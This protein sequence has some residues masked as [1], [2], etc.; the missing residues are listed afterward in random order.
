MKDIHDF[1]LEKFK[2][3]ADMVQ[4]YYNGRK[5]VFWGTSPLLQ[6]LL[7]RDYG[8]EVHCIVTGDKKLANDKLLFLDDF[9]DK[10]NEYYIVAPH[11]KDNQKTFKDHLKSLG[12][13]EFVDFFFRLHEKIELKPGSE[14]YHDSYGNHI[15]CKKASVVLPEWIYNATILV[16]DTVKFGKNSRI[17]MMACNSE[18]RIAKDCTFGTNALIDIYTS[19]KLTIEEGTTFG[20]DL[21]IVLNNEN[22]IKIGKDCMFSHQVKIY[23]GDGHA[24]FDLT[25]GKR[26]SIPSE[27]SV[28]IKN[29]VWVG[30]RATILYN[31]VINN[32][33]IVGAGAVVKGKFPNNCAIGGIP[34]KI[35]KKNVTWHRH[36]FQTEMEECGEENLHF[37]EEI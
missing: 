22:P 18:V 2:F 36:C 13:M 21:E 14:E 26:T 4:R 16:D 37:T 11:I 1:E 28:E 5:I 8:I 27:S 15:H 7:K 29:H 30:L 9:K 17:R 6:E 12:Y 10:S 20:S 35:L 24:I 3:A 34:A 19:N 31:T 23:S 33:C 25:T 32:S